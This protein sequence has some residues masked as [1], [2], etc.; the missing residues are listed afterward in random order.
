MVGLGSRWTFE[1]PFAG[2]GD[3]LSQATFLPPQGFFI[4]LALVVAVD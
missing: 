3:F 1:D 4:A 2:L